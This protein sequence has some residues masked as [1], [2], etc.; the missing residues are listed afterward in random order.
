MA[1]QPVNPFHPHSPAAS[2]SRS[3]YLRSYALQYNDGD[4][5]EVTPIDRFCT[6]TGEIARD[7]SHVHWSPHSLGE[8]TGRFCGPTV[9]VHDWFFSFSFGLLAPS[10]DA[11]TVRGKRRGK[12][13]A[14]KWAVVCAKRIEERRKRWMRMLRLSTGC[15]P[16]IRGKGTRRDGN[17][18]TH[19]S[20]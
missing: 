7:N 2:S 17:S 9:L 18:Q 11:H 6:V 3:V 8:V 20:P 16:C 1:H 15:P 19:Y 13:D 12:R 10:I 14:G 4:G 5:G